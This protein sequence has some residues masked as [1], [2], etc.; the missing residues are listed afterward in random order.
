MLTRS[1]RALRNNMPIEFQSVFQWLWLSSRS[2]KSFAA[3]SSHS[4][5][6]SSVTCAPS[7]AS[8]KCWPVALATAA[9]SSAMPAARLASCDT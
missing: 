1:L 2:A 8:Q 4:S 3:A 7:S 5:F 9:A 6:V